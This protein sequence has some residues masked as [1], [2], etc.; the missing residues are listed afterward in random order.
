MIHHAPVTLEKPVD[1]PAPSAWDAWRGV[2]L[3]I[4]GVTAARL[5]YLAF[6]CPYTLIEDETNYWEWSRHLAL[7]YYTKGPG[8]AWAVRASTTLLGETMFAVR[9]VAVLAAGVGA[10]AI[11]AMTLDLTASRR[12]AW[13]AVA[14]FFLTPAFQAT[15]LVTTIDGPFVA[16]WAVAAWATNRVLVRGSWRAWLAL[17]AAL[18]VGV[19]FK[20]TMLLFLVSLVIAWRGRRSGAPRGAARPLAAAAVFAALISPIIIW[21][22][23]HHWP[24]VG[25]LL[26]HLG[27][28]GGDKPVSQGA[29]GW[30]YKPTWTIGY[31][32]IQAAIG[33][34]ML[35][36]AGRAALGA[37][38]DRTANAAGWAAAAYLL[39]CSL[40]MFVFYFVVSLLTNPQGNWALAGFVTLCPLAGMA[41]AALA[42]RADGAGLF[43]GRS[44]GWHYRNAAVIVGLLTGLGMLRLDLLAHL[45]IVGPRIPSWRMMYADTMAQ[46]THEIADEMRVRTGHDPFV[47]ALHYGRA[48]QMAFYL[49]GR[50]QVYCCSSLLLDG[51]LNPYD[52]WPDTDLRQI[53]TG[54]QPGAF[55]IGQ[56]AVVLGASLEDWLPLFDRVEEVGT[57]RGDG[58]RGRPA[59]KGFG[60]RGFPVGGLRSAGT[61]EA[62][63]P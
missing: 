40:P 10:T 34:P 28:P 20:Y 23:A 37:W 51:R 50:P 47:M 31:L 60:F 32:V 29:G 14:V 6:F 52:F 57:L 22:Q 19:L 44:R 9:V 16:C 30:T 26:G 12:A 54:G 62:E 55:L 39:A 5:L 18:G 53:G 21:N 43:S 63:V 35:L 8:I 41:V 36:L 46:H 49:P 56:D 42:L 13:W 48:S 2:V 38:R 61:P 58:K 27:L 7:S 59:F 33:G 17:G 1:G 24:T 45:P 4:A 15:S 3:L 25:H 11:A